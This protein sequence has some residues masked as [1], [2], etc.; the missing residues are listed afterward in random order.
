MFGG[1]VTPPKP[2][3]ISRWMDPSQPEIE[4]IPS[5]GALGVGMGRNLRTCSR[6]STV[7]VHFFS[8]SR[9]KSL[10]LKNHSLRHFEY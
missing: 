6:D 3:P 9:P 1:A 10:T 5:Q 2:K 8:E 4:T 7:H